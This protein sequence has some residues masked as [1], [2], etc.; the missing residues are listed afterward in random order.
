MRPHVRGPLH[1]ACQESA[2][3]RLRLPLP[4]D[5]HVVRSE[6]HDLGSWDDPSLLRDAQLRHRPIRRRIRA[7]TFG[8]SATKA[9]D[10]GYIAYKI[11]PTLRLPVLVLAPKGLS[12]DWIFDQATATADLGC[13]T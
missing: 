8:I 5:E 6:E 10:G 7:W 2:S 11:L 3:H 13:R 9:L 1:Q 4:V 12:D